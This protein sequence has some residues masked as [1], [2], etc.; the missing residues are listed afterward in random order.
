MCATPAIAF[1]IHKILCKN[2]KKKPTSILYPIYNK[3]VFDIVF[4][5]INDNF[6]NSLCLQFIWLLYDKNI[7]QHNVIWLSWNCWFSRDWRNFFLWCRLLTTRSDKTRFKHHSKFANVCC[8]YW[9]FTVFMQRLIN[10]FLG[11]QF[12][13]LWPNINHTLY[14]IRTYEKVKLFSLNFDCKH[15]HTYILAVWLVGKLNFI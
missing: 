8:P 1:Q 10:S 5:C 2:H 15:T 12:F 14:I 11:L 13:F 4:L 9:V 3:I 7:F 6:N